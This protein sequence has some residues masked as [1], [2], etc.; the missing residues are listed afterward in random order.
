MITCRGPLGVELYLFSGIQGIGSIR[1][2][3]ANI[4]SNYEQWYKENI[5]KPS[6]LYFYQMWSE[7]N[8]TLGYL[9]S[10]VFWGNWDQCLHFFRFVHFDYFDIWGFK[11]PFHNETS[12]LF[13]SCWS[14]A[15]WLFQLPIKTNFRTLFCP[16]F[17]K[18][19][20]GRIFLKRT[21]FEL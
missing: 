20:N 19:H 13:W 9:G 8:C 5:S 7:W 15:K 4:S 18:F 6:N 10:R 2:N 14:I 16:H 11:F 21:I 3:W 17:L 1:G 12:E